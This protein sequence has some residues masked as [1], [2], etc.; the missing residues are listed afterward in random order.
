MIFFSCFYNLKKFNIAEKTLKKVLH[1]DPDHKEA[2]G[3]FKFLKGEME[4][5]VMEQ[6]SSPTGQISDNEVVQKF[7]KFQ[8]IVDNIE[9]EGAKK[10]K[11]K[12]SKK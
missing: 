1:L 7:E 2:R 10:I 5:E 8:T 9:E 3:L 12:K 11:K 6:E 4:S